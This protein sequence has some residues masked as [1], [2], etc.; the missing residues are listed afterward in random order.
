M[1]SSEDP[2]A[3]R[4]AVEPEAGEVP[5]ASSG[6]SPRRA[7]CPPRP[8]VPWSWTKGIWLVM[9][10]NSSSALSAKSGSWS[11]SVRK[12]QKR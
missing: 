11:S 12:T 5:A 1:S 7:V 2:E 8:W 3:G 10:A 4:S 9:N 6:M